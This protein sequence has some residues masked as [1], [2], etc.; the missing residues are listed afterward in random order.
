[1]T[2]RRV[3]T[4][5]QVRDVLHIYSTSTLGYESIARQFGIGASTVRDIIKRYTQY[6]AR[7]GL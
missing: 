2:R 4:D 7:I 6:S 3:L 5:S 1:M